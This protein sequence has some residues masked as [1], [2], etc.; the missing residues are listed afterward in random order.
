MKWSFILSFFIMYTIPIFVLFALSI[1]IIYIYL[2]WNRLRNTLPTITIVV[3]PMTRTYFSS[4]IKKNKEAESFYGYGVL[5]ESRVRGIET[6][7]DPSLRLCA[8]SLIAGD[9]QYRTSR[10]PV[11][12]FKNFST[13]WCFHGRNSDRRAKRR[14]T[15]DSGKANSE[16]GRKVR[17]QYDRT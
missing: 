12:F 9:I 1:C 13:E 4:S 7:W 17:R 11:R 14:L 3:K 16:T 6:I 5:N 8:V 2:T 15:S 10:A